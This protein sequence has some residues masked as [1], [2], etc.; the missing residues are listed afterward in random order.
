VYSFVFF[1]KD[2]N[3]PLAFA[4][5][6][7]LAILVYKLY[8]NGKKFYSGLIITVFLTPSILYMSTGYEHVYEMQPQSYIREMSRQHYEAALAKRLDPDLDYFFDYV[9]L[10]YYLNFEDHKEYLR[11]KY[12]GMNYY[13][14]EEAFSK[15]EARRARET[16]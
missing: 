3:Q 10:Y 11:S 5:A 7:V 12:G 13:E 16:L 4:S 15:E 2:L 9:N 6:L 1:R 14:F 8:D